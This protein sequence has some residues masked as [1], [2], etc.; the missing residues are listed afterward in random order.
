[1]D[2]FVDAYD[3]A[4]HGKKVRVPAHFLG[5]GSPFPNLRETP[6]SRGKKSPDA[7]ASPNSE[8]KK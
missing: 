5:E 1:M 3:N 4:N 7:G 6:M 2:G 8:E